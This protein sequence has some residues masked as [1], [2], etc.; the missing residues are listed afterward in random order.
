MQHSAQADLAWADYVLPGRSECWRRN[1]SSSPP[2][3]ERATTA[4]IRALAAPAPSTS[5]MAPPTRYTPTQI[6]RTCGNCQ[7]RQD[8]NISTSVSSFDTQLQRSVGSGRA[9]SKPGTRSRR[10][11]PGRR[12]EQRSANIARSP[13]E[14]ARAAATR[15]SE[16]RRARPRCSL[17]THANHR[18]ALGSTRSR[19][20]ALRDMQRR[21]WSPIM[22]PSALGSMRPTST[23]CI[24]DRSG[25][26][27]GDRCV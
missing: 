21:S 25:H 27:I 22:A 2:T 5:A 14:C 7:L 11:A 26:P 1:Q 13:R 24:A 12:N 20:C 18:P 15:D 19:A 4:P 9:S 6:Q 16:A 8:V 17:P 23:R 3:A 10:A